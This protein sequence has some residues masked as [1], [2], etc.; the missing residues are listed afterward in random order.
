MN[1]SDQVER[2]SRNKFS[3]EK[4][5]V[6][7]VTTDGKYFIGYSAFLIWGAVKINYNATLHHPSLSGVRAG[8][9]L[10]SHNSPVADNSAL[11]WHSPKLG[12]DGQWQQLASS[13]R[14]VLHQTEEGVVEWNCLQPSSRV[15]LTTAAG[16]THHGLGYVEC[17]NLNIPPWRLG[18]Q[19]LRW[20]RFVSEN[21]SVV[22]IE[23]QGKYNLIVLICDGQKAM[24][25]Q[26]S[27]YMVRC[28][29][30]ELSLEHAE[31]IREDSIGGT[32]ASK[33][34]SILKVAPIEFLGGK[35]QKYVSRGRLAFLGGSDHTGWVI[36]ERVSWGQNSI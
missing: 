18:L 23:W 31:T 33:I 16:T 21:H 7:M 36:H 22:W 29:E 30:F 24:N 26:I 3:L 15:Q 5:Y 13:E 14:R 34:P 28:D 32:L 17:L 10:S 9:S 1:Q 6:D 11:T 19:T 25:P 8:P 20:G 27:D 4:F 35:E 12:F 2:N